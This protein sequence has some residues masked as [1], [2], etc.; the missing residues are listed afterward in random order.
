[1]SHHKGKQKSKTVPGPVSEAKM[2]QSGQSLLLERQ[3]LAV[4]ASI[5][6]PLLAEEV[7]Q[8][9]ALLQF[10]V[11]LRQVQLLLVSCERVKRAE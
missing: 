3:L 10:A 7:F 6:L 4:F 11:L 5:P 8:L 1:M 2:S 9:A